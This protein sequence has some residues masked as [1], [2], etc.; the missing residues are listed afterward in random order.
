MVYFAYT[1][2][3]IEML[4][5]SLS[6][7]QSKCPEKKHQN[8]QQT[9]IERGCKI[10]R[11]GT[12]QA[13]KLPLLTFWQVVFNSFP[14]ASCYFKQ[15]VNFPPPFEQR[16]TL[17]SFSYFT[18]LGYYT[19]HYLNQKSNLN[20]HVQCL[21]GTSEGSMCWQSTMIIMRVLFPGFY[22]ASPKNV[23]LTCHILIEVKEKGYK[24]KTIYRDTK[25]LITWIYHGTLLFQV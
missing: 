6:P 23:K 8:S 19:P 13:F 2:E 21:P 4:L 3:S 11:R 15:K 10:V 12:A 1:A 17:Y 7:T 18:A 14:C 9:L 5:F 16:H 22:F 25:L 20:N 24:N